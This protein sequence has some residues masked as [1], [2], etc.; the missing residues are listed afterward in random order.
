VK[1]LNLLK[2]I[3]FKYIL[4][5]FFSSSAKQH[6]KAKL[7]VEGNFILKLKQKKIMISVCLLSLLSPVVISLAV[8]NMKSNKNKDGNPLKNLA[9]Q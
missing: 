1:A 7:A 2:V 5:N 3:S 6:R 9:S 8:V 4:T